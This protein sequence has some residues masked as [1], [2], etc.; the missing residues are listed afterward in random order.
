MIICIS[1]KEENI[2]YVNIKPLNLSKNK[3]TLLSLQEFDKKENP[4]F[5]FFK[6]KK[7][8]K[9]YGSYKTLA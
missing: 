4:I 3:I 1:K 5:I 7:T 2:F 8:W 9:I 6:L